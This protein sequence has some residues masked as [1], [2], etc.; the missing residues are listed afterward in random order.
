MREVANKSSLD[1][2][3]AGYVLAFNDDDA[4]TD[5]A[6]IE[7]C[8]YGLEVVGEPAVVRLKAARPMETEMLRV[9]VAVGLYLI[10]TH[11]FEFARLDQPGN[12]F[13]A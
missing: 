7:R 3:L 8:A 9:K 10:P 1:P 13:G 4:P 6:I 5:R 12:E 11:D 2:G